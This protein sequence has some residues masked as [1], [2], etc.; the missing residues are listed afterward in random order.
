MNKS[1]KKILILLSICLMLFSSFYLIN[2]DNSSS[3]L[4]EVDNKKLTNYLNNKE[5]LWIYVGR[6]TCEE[7]AEFEPTL[8]ETLKD[9]NQQIYYYDTDNAREDNEQTMIDL[10]K[11]LDVKVVPTIV[12]LKNGTVQDKIV[13][14]Q[15]ET[16]VKQFLLHKDKGIH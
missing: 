4:I 7:C 6:S 5:D 13:G 10:V 3:K 15:T 1:K 2:G 11:S 16:E 14:L 8:K 9:M 12:H